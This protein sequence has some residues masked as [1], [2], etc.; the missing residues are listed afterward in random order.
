MATENEIGHMKTSIHLIDFVYLS[1][2]PRKYCERRL[3]ES[4]NIFHL[5]DAQI[6]KTSNKAEMACLL[7][8]L[9]SSVVRK[10]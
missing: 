6:K 7:P 2:E 3:R 9:F 8:K 5:R 4:D 10:I 1:Y